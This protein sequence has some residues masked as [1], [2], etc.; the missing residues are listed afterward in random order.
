MKVNNNIFYKA[1]EM[2]SKN[3]PMLGL[4]A[5]SILVFMGIAFK[6][7]ELTTITNGI[8][9]LDFEIG[10]NQEKVM[11]TFGAYGRDG[12]EIY[13]HIQL[14]D[15]INPLAYSILFCCIF[16]RL[17]R[18]SKYKILSFLPLSMGLMDYA[19]NL[20]LYFLSTN[21]PDIS[22]SLVQMSS[23]FSVI[24]NV[25]ILVTIV[26]FA[27]LIAYKIRKSKLSY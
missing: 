22:N 13:M 2:L 6:L 18:P 14:I 19:E 16:Y 10:Y 9:I 11:T 5:F 15:L 7:T 20:T 21:F 25:A 26:T 17:L 1:L 4:C 23:F 3:K 27:V 12:M 24:K 8:G